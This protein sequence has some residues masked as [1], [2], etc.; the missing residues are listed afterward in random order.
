MAGV[1]GIFV[2]LLVGTVV[3]ILFALNAADNARVASERERIAT[4]ESYRARIAA[5]VGATS[6]HDVAD[7]ARQLDAAPEALRD[8]EWRHL[9]A[10]L[11]DSIA[12]F[13]AIAGESQFLFSDPNGVRIARLARASLRL[14]DLEG[15]EL[16]ARSFPPE[17]NLI[18]HPPLATRKGLRLLAMVPEIRASSIAFSPDEPHPKN[19]LNLLDDEGRVVTHLKGPSGA[20]TNLVAVSPDGSRLAVFGR[21]RRGGYLPCMTLIRANQWRPR[22]MKSAT[23]GPLFST[24]TA[25]ASP[26]AA[27]MA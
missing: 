2:A 24:Q 6:H 13:P 16:W 5:A 27:K 21:A 22:P 26:P 7:A 20:E 9:H 11:D 8:W 12:V 4:D 1:S 17:T 25:R 18:H 15:N 10:R 19:I 14:A 3:S 23:P